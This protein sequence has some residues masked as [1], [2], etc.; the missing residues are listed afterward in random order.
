MTRIRDFDIDVTGKTIFLL[1]KFGEKQYMEELRNTGNLYMR[2]L[3]SFLHLEDGQVRGDPDEGLAM[4]L[5][6]KL[7][8]VQFGDIIVP[9]RDM[10]APAKVAYNRTRAVHVFSMYAISEPQ[11]DAILK[12]APPIER[13][14]LDFGDHAV[15]VTNPE[16]FL[17]RVMLAAEAAGT[18]IA[19]GLVH[20]LDPRTHHGEL[21]PFNKMSTYAWQSEYRIVIAA[22][23]TE[24]AYLR[25]GSIEDI[26]MLVR[27][28]EINDALK[29]RLRE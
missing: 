3:G 14:L 28:T 13:R 4:F 25:L 10:V 11:V 9:S 1:M 27:T 21:S 2:T 5:Q 16:A 6:P 15:V 7:I 20:Y 24:V 26:T 17:A 12:G 8:Q 23:G 22:T 19:R 29:F 18:N